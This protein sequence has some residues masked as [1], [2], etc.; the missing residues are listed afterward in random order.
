MRC[1]RDT[2]GRSFDHHSLQLMRQQA[3]KAVRNGQSAAEVAVSFGV[4][5][6]TVFRWL[7]SFA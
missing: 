7:A 6:R 4:N 3:V 2:D 5:E 1:K